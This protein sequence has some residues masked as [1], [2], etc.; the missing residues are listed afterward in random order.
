MKNYNILLF[1]FFRLISIKKADQSS[2]IEIKTIPDAYLNATGAFVSLEYFKDSNYIYFSY[3][4][5]FHNKVNP[6]DLNIAYFKITSEL[7]FFKCDFK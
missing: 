2:S 1:I 3:D 4:F 6:K 7:Y 5:I